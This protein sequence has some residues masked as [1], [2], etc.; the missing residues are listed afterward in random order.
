MVFV[1]GCKYNQ[2]E[3]PKS[4]SSSTLLP[5]HLHN[6][7]PLLHHPDHKIYKIIIIRKNGITKREKKIDQNDSIF[8]FH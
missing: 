7:H 4:S 1:F 8:H 2:D 5:Q 3:Q 6:S